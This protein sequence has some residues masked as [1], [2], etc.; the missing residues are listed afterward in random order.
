MK[1][2]RKA[3]IDSI[4]E[5]FD[6]PHFNTFGF[7]LTS[8]IKNNE[9]TEGSEPR[10]LIDLDLRSMSIIHWDFDQRQILTV[11]KPDGPHVQKGFHYKGTVQ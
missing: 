5:T 7:L 3:R 6:D 9:R 11:Q 1:T 8:C 10:Y 2:E 4:H